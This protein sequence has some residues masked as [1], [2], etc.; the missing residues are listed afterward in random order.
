MVQSRDQFSGLRSCVAIE[1]PASA[2]KSILAVL[3][4]QSIREQK[5]G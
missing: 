5:N 4:R 3:R 1:I 2:L